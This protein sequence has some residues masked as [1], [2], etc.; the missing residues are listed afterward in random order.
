MIIVDV[1][2]EAVRGV[3][4][5]PYPTNVISQTATPF[6]KLNF[7]L[8]QQLRGLPSML[9]TPFPAFYIPYKASLGGRVYSAMG[10]SAKWLVWH[11]NDR[12]A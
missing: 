10:K 9:S 12:F 4:P 3:L 8:I 7:S 5:Y 11:L 6:P 2:G 1:C